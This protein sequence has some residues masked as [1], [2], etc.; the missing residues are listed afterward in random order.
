[1]TITKEGT[2]LTL[3]ITGIINGDQLLPK[4]DLKGIKTLVF[5]FDKVDAINSIGVKM[6]IGFLQE[7]PHSVSIK[8]SHCRRVV[9]DQMNMISNFKPAHVTVVSFYVPYHCANCVTAIPFLYILGK[10][11]EKGSSRV[12]HPTEVLCGACI[13]PAQIDVIEAKYFHFLSRR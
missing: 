12:T 7:L 9:V 2:T 3:H 6:W 10:N 5:D 13:L 4:L 8:Y 11:F 1:M